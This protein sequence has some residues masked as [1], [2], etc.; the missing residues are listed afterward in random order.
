MQQYRKQLPEKFDRPFGLTAIFALL[1]MAVQ[2]V[3]SFHSHDPSSSEEDHGP[4][5]LHIECGICLIATMPL[6]SADGIELASPPTYRPIPTTVALRMPPHD[7][8]I[9]PNQARAPPRA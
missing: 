7:Q 6:H 2:I 8:S 1:F 5:P 4:V 3:M 9:L